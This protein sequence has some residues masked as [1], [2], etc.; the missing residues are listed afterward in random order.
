MLCMC[1][2][3]QHSQELVIVIWAVSAL[4]ASRASAF[5]AETG[6]GL[7]KYWLAVSLLIVAGYTELVIATVHPLPARLV[8]YG[9]FAAVRGAANETIYVCEGL[10]ASVAVSDL[11]GGMRTYH[12][13]GT[14]PSSSDPADML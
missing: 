2:G 3:A 6:T 14:V 13:A 4:F 8:E 12:N 7:S 10:T 5:G 11:P 1:M 9:R